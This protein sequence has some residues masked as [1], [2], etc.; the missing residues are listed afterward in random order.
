MFW[1]ASGQLPQ[2]PCFCCS[3]RLFLQ[4]LLQIYVAFPPL[5]LAAESKSS[6]PWASRR[7]ATW[8]PWRTPSM[9]WLMRGRRPTRTWGWTDPDLS[10]QPW[11]AGEPPSALPPELVLHPEASTG[12]GLS[13]WD[14]DPAWAPQSITRNTTCLLPSS[15]T[16]SPSRGSLWPGSA[17]VS[18][19]SSLEDF[20]LQIASRTF[21]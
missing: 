13:L 6:S 20:R 12:P 18:P 9:I 17:L 2:A 3:A 1:A 10:P 4:R 19:V 14:L 8:P 11:R 5:S 16:T 21:Q 15:I 7:A